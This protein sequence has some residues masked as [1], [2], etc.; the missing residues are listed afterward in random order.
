MVSVNP[1]F[2]NVI[3]QNRNVLTLDKEREK[4]SAAKQLTQSCV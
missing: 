1:Q 3:G 2:I 4:K